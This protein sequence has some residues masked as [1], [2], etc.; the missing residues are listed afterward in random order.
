MITI[1]EDEIYDN[2]IKEEIYFDHQKIDDESAKEFQDLMFWIVGA[3]ESGKSTRTIK[4]HIYKQDIDKDLEERMKKMFEEQA[5]NITGVKKEFNMNQETI[6]GYTFKEIIK[7]RKLS[8]QKRAIS[9]MSQA[10]EIIK[11]DS[12]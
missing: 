6:G 1:K 5:E 12:K 8:I 3:L 7:Q 11:N 10:Q 4:A 2:A 9:F